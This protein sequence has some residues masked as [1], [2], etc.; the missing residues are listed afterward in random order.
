MGSESF[1]AR[2][3][4]RAG[5]FVFG[6]LTVGLV[7]ST[8]NSTPAEAAAQVEKVQLMPGTRWESEVTV[9]RS[10]QPGPVVMAVGGVH[11]DKPAGVEAG[12][13]L[14]GFRDL[15]RGTLL[16]VPALDRVAVEAGKHTVDVNTNRA[17]PTRNGQDP[18][19]P[20]A[21]DLWNV[22]KKYG[23]QYLV[24][25]HEGSRPWTTANSLGNVIVF[26][27]TGDNTNIANK[28][29]EAL[30]RG[31]SQQ[32]RWKLGGIPISSGL[33]RA[34]QDHLGI[35]SFYVSTAKSNALNTRVA[36]HETAVMTLLRHL[37]MV[38]AT[39]APP[40]DPTPPKT[41]P[42]TP[43]ADPT[44]PSGNQV[45]VRK[46]MAGTTFA[47]DLYI[48][49]S[50]RPGPTVWIS[51]GVHGSEL[52]GWQAA[53][54]ISR[55]RVGR[56]RL[57]VLPH[58]NKLGVQQRK[59]EPSGYGDLNRQFPTS[60]RSTPSTQMARGIWAEL[61]RY[62]PDWVLDLHE[63][64]SNRN[65]NKNSVGQ[66]I[67][68]VNKGQMPSMAN[69]LISEVNRGVSS[70]KKFQRLINPVVGSLARA[71][72]DRLGANAAIVETSRLYSLSERINWHLTIVE[73][74]L[75]ELDMA[76]STG[77]SAFQHDSALR[78]A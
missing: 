30:N 8:L 2:W 70:V 49:D 65:L 4:K 50:G 14:A 45:T 37:N 74:L 6:L 29:L 34:A 39:S 36:Q 71:A 11:G 32:Q 73:T 69:K 20:L 52:A 78:V 42:Q 13:K 46:I 35:A 16:V 33:A 44:P 55:W 51:G 62:Q 75:E 22:M 23:V 64:M 15:Q 5:R 47:T 76:P 17:F 66:T 7:L 59:R 24:D 26:Q 58:A 38:G 10:G 41:P 31:V 54:R 68:V 21:R 48:I 3:L 40:S 27:K 63:A 25:M 19:D 56:G 28:L 67:I 77:Q 18:S 53:E 61:Q 43:P 1:K 9:I 12:K 60:S 72:G 57:I